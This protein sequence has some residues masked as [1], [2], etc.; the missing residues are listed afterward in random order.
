MPGAPPA[1][2]EDKIAAAQVELHRQV[3]PVRLAGDGALAGAQRD[4]RHL[5]ERDARAA[6][7]GEREVADRLRAVAHAGD[8]AHRD[9]VALLAE[10]ELPH[11]PAADADLDQVGDVGDVDAEARRRLAVHLDLKLRQRR[12][13]VDGHVHRAGRRLERRHHLLRHAA[14][15]GEVVAVDLHHELAVRAGDLVVDAVDHRLREADRDA[16]GCARSGRSAC[17]IRSCLVS[18][19]GQ[20]S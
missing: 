17:A 16:R 20:V 8:E 4:L 14:R 11:R 13:L 1:R 10:E 2:K 3:A 12:L 9:V 15:L 7:R 6:R 19:A 5:R 18:P